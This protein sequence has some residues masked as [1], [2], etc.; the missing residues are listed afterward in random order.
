MEPHPPLSLWLSGPHQRA[1]CAITEAY[2]TGRV[3][4]AYMQFY[5]PCFLLFPLCW[6][7][8]AVIKKSLLKCLFSYNSFSHSNYH[9]FI[10]DSALWS[11]VDLER[12]KLS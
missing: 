8:K 4:R 6:L 5:D 11:K 9:W 12:K 1:H 7:R 3:N 2:S 10:E